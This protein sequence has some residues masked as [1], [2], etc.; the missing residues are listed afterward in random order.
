MQ[1]HG[2]RASGNEDPGMKE[3]RAAPG[4]QLRACIQR[5][6]RIFG[7]LTAD[8]TPCG[9][10]LSPSYA[11]ALMVLLDRQRIDDP[12]GQQDLVKVL[13]INK[14]NVA[15]LCAKMVE[16][17]HVV[18]GDSPTDGRAWTLRLTAS[19]QRLA[20]R[21][22]EASHTRFDR[23]LAALPSPGARKSVIH[24][25]EML[26]EAIAATRRLEETR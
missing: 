3:V 23:V 19:G 7:L 1:K 16:G 24:A 9:I 15:R 12:C 25:L 14:S 20:A 13:G 10:A 8:Q 5:F 22:E 11:H 6:V 4:S 2:P 21:V 17:G 26:N 18:Q